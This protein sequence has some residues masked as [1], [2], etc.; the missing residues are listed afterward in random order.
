MRD[1]VNDN[2]VLYLAD[3]TA[4][5]RYVDFQQRWL[6]GDYAEAARI[7]A[8]ELVIN[9]NVPVTSDELSRKIEANK[10]FKDELEHTIRQSKWSN[11][12][13]F[14]FN[15]GYLPLHYT[16][17]PLRF[18]DVPKIRTIATYGDRIVLA[19]SA[20]ACIIAEQRIELDEQLL[21]LVNARIKRY[22]QLNREGKM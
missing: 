22:E 12:T 14:K 9:E 6:V 1:S 21:E 8:P 11:V 5:D 16:I 20:F 7:N 13:A 2:S 17:G 4:S 15:F 3:G 10:I 19:N 18:I